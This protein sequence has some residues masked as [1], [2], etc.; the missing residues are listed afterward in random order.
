MLARI[1]RLVL[2][3]AALAAA[4]CASLP[5][6][7]TGLRGK[8]IIIGGA[9]DYENAGIYRRIVAEA[10]PRGIAVLPTASGVPHESGPGAARRLASYE[11]EAQ[12]VD[13][14]TTAPENAGDPALAEAIRARGG[15][16]FTGGVQTRI[17]NT[18]LPEGRVTPAMQAVLDVLDAGGVVAGTSAGAA[19]M[20]DPMILGGT[21]PAALIQGVDDS[22][23]SDEPLH[24]VGIG[25]GTG[26][27]PFTLVDQ[28]HIERARTGRLLIALQH[29]GQPRGFGIDENSA[30]LVDRATAVGEVLPGVG[31]LM[32]DVTGM[33]GGPGEGL[34]GARLSILRPGDRVDTLTGRVTVADT[35][36]RPVP[37]PSPR[38][39][40]RRTAENAFTD[41]VYARAI[42]DLTSPDDPPAVIILDDPNFTVTLT[43]DERTRLLV[44]PGDTAG[45]ILDLRIDIDI[46]PGA[47]VPPPPVED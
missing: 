39:A 33:T 43:R 26:I 14:T 13:I 44:A 10:G 25:R 42:E 5:V 2:A 24:G 32:A 37:L 36:T 31:V 9:L 27:F 28:H 41:R 4:G 12:V 29:L 16:F 6:R 34:H 35:R 30:L 23:A 17:I 7:D 18:L 3:A 46:K 8:L 22:G 11:A 40:V 21:A 45:T 20:S 38:R 15:V 47:V 19:M 1:T